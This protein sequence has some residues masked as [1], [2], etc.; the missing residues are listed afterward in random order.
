MFCGEQLSDSGRTVRNL[1]PGYRLPAGRGLHDEHNEI[2]A[3]QGGEIS[4]GIGDQQQRL[5][6]PAG[7]EQP[8]TQTNSFDLGQVGKAHPL[9]APH[10]RSSRAQIGTALTAMFFHQPNGVDLHSLIDRFAHIING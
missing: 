4:V 8:R 10:R 3:L 7:D 9:T 5:A 2:R 6:D 1:V